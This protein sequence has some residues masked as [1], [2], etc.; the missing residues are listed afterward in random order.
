M[1][2]AKTHLKLRPRSAE[3]PLPSLALSRQRR[4]LSISAP[5]VVS[6][7]PIDSLE[8]HQA[9]IGWLN[10]LASRNYRLVQLLH[11]GEFVR[12]A[13]FES[14]QPWRRR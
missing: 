2:L 7:H 3:E 10:E 6:D 13:L 9:V 14:V 11:D 8:Y 1:S 4:Y 5:P 12:A